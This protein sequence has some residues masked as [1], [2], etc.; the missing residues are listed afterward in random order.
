MQ[1]KI[2]FLINQDGIDSRILPSKKVVYLYCQAS[3]ALLFQY[4]YKYKYGYEAPRKY[5]HAM[6]LDEKNGKNLWKDAVA[7]EL[8]QCYDYQTFEDK[9]HH[10]KGIPPNGY[11]KICVHFVFDVKHDG[12]HKTRLVADGH[13]TDVPL[14]SVYSGFVIIKGFQIGNIPFRAQ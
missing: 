7:L 10:T 6:L 14:D 13:L 1:T 11:K 12:R 3:Q 5:N 4:I 9:G 2:I 8:Q